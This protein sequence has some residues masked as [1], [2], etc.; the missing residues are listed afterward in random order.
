MSAKNKI[1]K[2]NT[3]KEEDLEKD[4]LSVNEVSEQTGY[5]RDY[6]TY[7]ARTGRLKASKI[8]NNWVIAKSDLQAY[9]NSRLGQEAGLSDFDE[10]Q[11]SKA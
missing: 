5:H 2:T 11:T 9:K 10:P 6:V 7:L 3:L 8:G 1:K 4:L